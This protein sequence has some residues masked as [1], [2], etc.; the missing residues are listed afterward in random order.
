MQLITEPPGFARCV[1]GVRNP[2]WHSRH[3]LGSGVREP[4]RP[5]ATALLQT[6]TRAHPMVLTE[7]GGTW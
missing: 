2:G 1:Q 5:A 7:E 4:L 6:E 3:A